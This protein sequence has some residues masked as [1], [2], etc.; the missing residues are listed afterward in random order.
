M[1]GAGDR[2]EDETSE[3]AEIRREL[4]RHAPRLADLYD[5]AVRLVQDVSF[6]GRVRLAAH[7]VREIA[8]ALPEVILGVRAGRSSD[9]L[10]DDVTAAWLRELPAATGIEPALSD[11]ARAIPAA[12]MATVPA[13]VFERLDEFF[14]ARAKSLNRSNAAEELFLWTDPLNRWQKAALSPVLKE[15]LDTTRW[16]VA[17]SKTPRTRSAGIEDLSEPHDEAEFQERFARFQK[18]LRG[19]WGAFFKVQKEIEDIVEAQGP[20]GLDELLLLLAGAEQRRQFFNRLDDPAWLRPLEEKGFFSK[21][22]GPVHEPATGDTRH[23]PQPALLYLRRMAVRPEAQ[24]DVARIAAAL[25]DSDNVIV[26]DDL[27]EIALALP[28]VLAAPL[29][30][31][32]PRWLRAPRTYG[33]SRKIGELADRLA[34][35]GYAR[36]ALKLLGALL[37]FAPRQA[38]EEAQP[39]PRDVDTRVRVEGLRD[40]L[41]SRLPSLIEAAPLDV[42][43]LLSRRLDA[44]LSALNRPDDD[45]GEDYLQVWQRDVKSDAYAD[46]RFAV[47]LVC[48]LRDAMVHAAERGLVG[49]GPVLAVVDAHRWR[50]FG[51]L[52]MHL[53]ASVGEGS[54]NDV[55]R[56]LLDRRLLDRFDSEYQRLLH[57]CFG[58]LEPDQ[59]QKVLQWIAEGPGED[60]AQQSDLAGTEEKT[61]DE[62]VREADAW[63]WRRLGLIQPNLTGEWQDRWE[64]LR[65]TFGDPPEPGSD[66]IRTTVSQRVFKSPVPDEQWRA[67][68]IADQVAFL[69]AWRRPEDD[70]FVSPEGLREA[71]A[72]A[73]STEAERY[74][75]DAEQ[76][77]GLPPTFVRG[78]VGGLLAAVE[79]RSAF[80]WEPVLG[81]G[82]WIVTQQAV[83]PG[84][85]PVW[86]EDRGWAWTWSAL[87]RLLS[88]GFSEKAAGAGVPR[89]L[90]PKVWDVIAKL[91]SGPVS[92]KEQAIET[93]L[94]YTFWVRSGAKQMTSLD[95]DVPEVGRVLARE[96]SASREL[97]PELH[98]AYGRLLPWL[99]ALDPVWVSTHRT[100]V[101]PAE[102]G[103]QDRWRAAWTAYVTSHEADRH[104][105]FP[106]LAAEYERAVEDTD[107]SRGSDDRRYSEE[108]L[109]SHLI[110]LYL[111]GD[112][113]VAGKNALLG[114][115]F[116]VADLS[117]RQH[118]LWSAAED[119]EEAPKVGP[120]VIERLMALWRYRVT[121]AA[122]DARAREELPAFGWWFATARFDEDWALDQLEA[123]LEIAGRVDATHRVVERLAKLAPERPRVAARLLARLT[124]GPGEAL[125]ALVWIDDAR[126]ILVEAVR[127]GDPAAYSDAMTARDQLGKL[128]FAEVKHLLP[129]SQDLDDPQ[130]IPYFLWDQPMTVAQ[131]R[132]RLARASA[133]E[134]ERLLARILREARD[135]DV[136][137]FTSPREVDALWPRLAEKVGRKRS[138]WEFLLGQW[139][140]KGFLAG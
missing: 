102:P 87:A 76:F 19:L 119:L 71:I 98:R 35:G 53:L 88:S 91:V 122:K 21:P 8:N 108:C 96:I 32:A 23:P 60:A 111:R 10:L 97:P 36:Q 136:W 101:F 3:R 54:P 16:F 15:W 93:A 117:L 110:E 41:R 105:S 128:G 94:D 5:A 67:K 138:F 38:E 6:P 118:A 123:V 62:A 43:R 115:F 121:R 57:G 34:R 28:P 1:S 55:A 45:E 78:V 59:R 58:L 131:L 49:M 112:I 33:L 106:I 113:D 75:R 47:L 56:Y 132:E 84:T 25:P 86:G 81:L 79:A 63:R 65:R 40:I 72:R 140:E 116:D 70:P 24:E 80:P 99:I 109:V 4:A 77:I 11:A 129:L 95:A 73:V 135:T 124:A 120:Q 27:T 130:A 22:E 139:R 2:Q 125:E 68:P 100:E 46:R 137:K 7:A 29:A 85:T 89:E 126:R 133:P 134:R 52:A 90:R 104:R 18:A 31:K 107:T 42:V 39:W 82:Q 83:E 17:M 127:S 14:R 74:A 50:V 66:A 9:R 30:Q 48:V 92:V 20:G 51:R 13:Y 12:G 103:Q 44:V 64:Q 69:R 26:N 37:D 61:S 114:R